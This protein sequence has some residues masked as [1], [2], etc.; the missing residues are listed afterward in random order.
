VSC[1]GKPTRAV[2]HYEDIERGLAF[3]IEYAGGRTIT[4]TGSVTGQHYTFSGL[5]RLQLV[6][7]RDAPVLLRERVFRL[8]RVIQPTAS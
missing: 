7:P 8:A 1:C 4:I 5:N 2:I 3:E 6:D